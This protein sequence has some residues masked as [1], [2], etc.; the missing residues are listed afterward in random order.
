MKYDIRNSKNAQQ[1]L[2]SLTGV[3]LLI[4]KQ[5]VEQE[6]KFEYTEDLVEYVA[7]SYGK[8]PKKL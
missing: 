7:S 5:Y 4:W 8:I 6:N 1:T 2:I 3:P